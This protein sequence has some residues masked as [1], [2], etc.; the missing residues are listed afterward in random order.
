M[1][2]VYS[3]VVHKNMDFRKS[4]GLICICARNVIRSK[5]N[6]FETMFDHWFPLA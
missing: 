5:K 6:P 2:S 1:N 4:L 3:M